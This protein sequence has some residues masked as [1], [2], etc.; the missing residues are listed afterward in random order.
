[1]LEV[2]GLENKNKWLDIV[3]Q[4]KNH[5]VYYLPQYTQAFQI[6]GDGQPGLFYFESEKFKAINVVMKRDISQCQYFSKA[7]SRD[8]LFD[9]TTPYGYGGFLIEGET[10]SEGLGQLNEEYT[11]YCREEGIVSE[12]VRFH[13][14]L[15]NHIGLESVY[16]IKELGRAISMDLVSPQVIESNIRPKTRKRINKAVS[17]GI[18]VYHGNTQELYTTFKKM[19]DRTMDRKIA[20]QYYYFGERFYQSILNDMGDRAKIFYATYEGEIVAMQI[21]LSCNRRIYSH[22]SASKREYQFLSPGA[23]IKYKTALWGCENG[24]DAFY[25]GGGVGSHEDNLYKYKHKFNINSDCRFVTGR[26]IFD[27]EQYAQLLKIRKSA[28]VLELDPAYFPAYRVADEAREE[29]G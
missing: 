27:E 20:D 11:A 9:I 22:L 8:T 25:L 4:F 16:E 1:M 28:S 26:K 5:E 7:F 29:A 15:E 21:V 6:H 23:L 3:L 17:D 13:P 2:I 18:K 12:F 24:F 19:Y 10:D 14:L